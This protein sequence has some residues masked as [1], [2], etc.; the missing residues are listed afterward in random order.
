MLQLEFVMGMH[1]EHLNEFPTVELAK[2]A[3]PKLS[4]YDLGDPTS[5]EN[6]AKTAK[7]YL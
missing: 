4:Q 3:S 1:P 2:L 6:I 7:M 5:S